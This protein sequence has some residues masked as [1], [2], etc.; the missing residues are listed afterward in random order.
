MVS[1]QIDEIKYNFIVYYYTKYNFK[2]KQKIVNP[3][4]FISNNGSDSHKSEGGSDS[5]IEFDK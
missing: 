3:K 2:F 4:Q 5:K 1:A